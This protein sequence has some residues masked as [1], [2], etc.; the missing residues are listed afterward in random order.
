MVKA[1]DHSSLRMSKQMA[2]VCEEIFG[3]HILVSNCIFGGTYGYLSGILMSIWKV[4][5]SYTLSSGPLMVPFQCLMFS[6]TVWTVVP[7]LFDF[8]LFFF[9]YCISIFN[10]SIFILFLKIYCI[11]ILP[12]IGMHCIL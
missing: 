10:I 6:F 5:P 12:L 9:Y 1:G 8:G 2:P 11:F 7:S 4:P 3:C